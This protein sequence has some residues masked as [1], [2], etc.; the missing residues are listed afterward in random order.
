M[1]G[2]INKEIVEW[3]RIP[4]FISCTSN[5]ARALQRE[6]KII[7]V[8]FVH[9]A[10][11]LPSQLFD[12]VVVP[13]TPATLTSPATIRTSWNTPN[14]SPSPLHIRHSDLAIGVRTCPALSSSTPVVLSFPPLQPH[15]HAHAI[16]TSPKHHRASVVCASRYSSLFFRPHLISRTCRHSHHTCI[17]LQPRQPSSTLAAPSSL[18]PQPHRHVRASQSCQPSST[19]DSLSLSVSSFLLA[20]CLPNING[21]K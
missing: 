1:I 15:R 21:P 9:P 14:G 3:S 18:P 16:L 20:M 8:A 6:K 7:C 10:T 19:P 13:V 4:L 12:L 5:Y 17:K 11:M 2:Q